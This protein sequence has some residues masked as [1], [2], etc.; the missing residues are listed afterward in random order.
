MLQIKQ[1]P[2]FGDKKVD[3][4]LAAIEKSRKGKAAVLLSALGIPGVGERMATV[5]LRC[6]GSIPVRAYIPR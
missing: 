2:K 5:L 6:F 1:L 3:N 4:L